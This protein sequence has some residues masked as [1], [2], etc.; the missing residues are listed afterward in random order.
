MERMR[1]FRWSLRIALALLLAF[2]VVST[3][4]PQQMFAAPIERANASYV[5]HTVRPGDTLSRIAEHYDVSM[6]SIMRANGIV[7]PNHIY[8][9]QRLKIPTGSVGCAFYHTVTRGQTL[10]GIAVYYGVRLS[11]LAEANGAGP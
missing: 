1:V 10:S 4:L 6:S 3:V 2:A 5:Y 7:N 9:G 8:V 11:A